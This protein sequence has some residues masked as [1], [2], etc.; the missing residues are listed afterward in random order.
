[1]PKMNVRVQH[2]LP[3]AEAALRIK[4][5]IGELKQKFGNRIQNLQE[6]WNGN[7]GT[8]SFETMGFKLSGTL[9]VDPSEVQIEGSLPFG[10]L[11]FRGMVEEA[12]LEKAKD[13]LS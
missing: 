13:L 9:S 12:I 8:F 11:P 1:M 5:L 7:G 6:T 2:H 10:A 4:N 3:Q